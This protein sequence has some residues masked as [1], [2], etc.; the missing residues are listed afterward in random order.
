MDIRS[1]DS[2]PHIASAYPHAIFNP[3]T[4][5]N[6]AQGKETWPLRISS[7]REAAVT[8]WK[9]AGNV[10]RPPTAPAARRHIFVRNMSSHWWV[11]EVTN[12]LEHSEKARAIEN[13]SFSAKRNGRDMDVTRHRHGYGTRGTVLVRAHGV[14]QIL[15][16]GISQVRVVCLPVRKHPITPATA[17]IN[18]PGF[19]SL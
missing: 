4:L 8:S 6:L 19:L 15:P 7:P 13:L 12:R 2:V 3:L 11:S 18:R 5:I 1:A 17:C 14:I 10:A 16:L 9:K